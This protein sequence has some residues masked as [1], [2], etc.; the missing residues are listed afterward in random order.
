MSE[1]F[2]VSD[3]VKLQPGLD[4][5]IVKKVLFQLKKEKAIKLIGRGR[6]ARWSR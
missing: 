4:R 2:S 1:S 5:E 3:L 6:G